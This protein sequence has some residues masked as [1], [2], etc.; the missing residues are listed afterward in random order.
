MKIFT[1]RASLAACGLAVSI[2]LAAPAALAQQAGT[3]TGTNSEG[4]GLEVVVAGSQG[5]Y[6]ITGVSDGGNVYCKTTEIG[7]WG[8]GIGTDDPITGNTATLNINYDTVYYQGSFKF[9]GDKVVVKQLFVVPVLTGT[10]TPPKTAC[11]ASTGTSTTTL[12]L[13]GAETR[14]P[15]PTVVHAA[16]FKIGG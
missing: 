3:Y 10:K 15:G 12:T 16:P 4:Y 13:S 14:A 11:G 9:S 5:N 8:L 2:V 7:G 6:E 1:T